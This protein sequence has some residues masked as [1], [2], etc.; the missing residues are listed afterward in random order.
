MRR[1]AQ[2][3]NGTRRGTALNDVQDEHDRH[4]GGNAD[5]H[6][7]TELHAAIV[8]AES[9]RKR[10]GFDESA[11]LGELVSGAQQAV[12]CAPQRAEELRA[13]ERAW[14]RALEKR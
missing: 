5:E 13:F 1:R 7:A 2:G 6:E 12:H 4:G 9:L 3:R 10:V 8:A 11:K 14:E